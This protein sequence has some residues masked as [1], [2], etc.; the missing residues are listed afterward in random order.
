MLPQ[1]A[2][3]HVVIAASISARAGCFIVVVCTL[4]VGCSDRQKV[5]HLKL[6]HGLDPSHSVHKAMRFADQRL[7]EISGQTMA[8]DIYPSR[9]LGGER[10]LIELLQIGS[11]SMTKVSS[12][13]LA[14]FVAEMQLFDLPYLFKDHQHY[15]RVL[16]SPL[17]KQLLQAPA[18]A[19]LLGLGYYDSGSRSFYTVDKTVVS[20]EDLTGL[21][22][23]VQESKTATAMVKALGGSPTPI[24]WGEL[25]TALQ[26]GVVDGAENNVPSYFLSRHYEAAPHFTLDEHTAVPDVLLISQYVWKTLTDQQQQWLQQAVDESIVFQRQLWATDTALALAE[27]QREGVVVTRPDKTQFI[28]KIQS[29]LASYAGTPV[30][31]MIEQIKDI[32]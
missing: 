16:D 24:A 6:G 5:L 27:I 17:G 14:S 11:L 2:G 26:Q 28:A 31:D 7:R 29:L 13:P 10:E 9:Q 22:I 8:I 18:S 21:K 19:R 1:S 23:R 3:G 4:L 25:Y 12:S 30:G 20:P 15:L 32:P